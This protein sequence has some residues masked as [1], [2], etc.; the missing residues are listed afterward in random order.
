[1]TAVVSLAADAIFATDYKVVRPLSEGGMGAVYV[2]EQ[3]STGKQRALK[4]MHPRFVADPRSRA[5]FV[6]EARVA[7]KIESDHVVEVVSAGVDDATDVPWLAMELLR[8]E[9]LADAMGRR[10]SLP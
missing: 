8:G 3:L 2:V 9:T 5:R 1:M 4:L 10:G 6:Q 7:A